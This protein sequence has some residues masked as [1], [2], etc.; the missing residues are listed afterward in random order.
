MPEITASFVVYVAPLEP[1]LWISHTRLL[2]EAFP[3][4]ALV[5][6]VRGRFSASVG[7]AIP[8]IAGISLSHADSLTPAI[9]PF[10]HR[11]SHL[12]VKLL[13]TTDVATDA[14][15][16]VMSCEFG[17][18]DWPPVFEREMLADPFKPFLDFLNLPM[19]VLL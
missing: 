17:F 14:K 15:I 2:N 8:D 5:C 13:Q 9:H 19:Q 10:E 1:C 7:D 16:A 4:L 12:E 6:T 18:Q 11:V 3:V